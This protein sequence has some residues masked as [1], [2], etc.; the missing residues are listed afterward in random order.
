M[1]LKP[2]ILC[3]LS[4]AQQHLAFYES[5]CV[6]TLVVDRL[7][8]TRP[9]IR[10]KPCRQDFES[11]SQILAQLAINKHHLLEGRVNFSLYQRLH[12]TYI[13][14]LITLN[15]LIYLIIIN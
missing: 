1:S 10:H 3:C 13:H 5:S 2:G 14:T 11:S 7:K 9:K 6:P 4:A 15:Q 8:P 12:S